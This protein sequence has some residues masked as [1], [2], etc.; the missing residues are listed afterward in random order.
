MVFPEGTRSI[1]NTV[2][3]F[4]KGAFYLAEQ[5]NLDI[6][7]VVIHGYSEC[8]PKGDF[9]LYKASTTVEI[10]ERIKSNDKSFGL[11]YTERTKTINSFLELSTIKFVPKKKM[12]I[13]SKALFLIVLIIKKLKL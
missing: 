7:P 1:D 5:F 12:L 13:T 10:L 4:H 8:S 2:K 3:R 11:N 6:V 9:M